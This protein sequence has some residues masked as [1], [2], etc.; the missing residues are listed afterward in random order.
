MS[1]DISFVFALIGI[2][3][4]LMASNRVRYDLVALIVV[5]ALIMGNILT[6]G[7]ALSGFG[8]SVVILVAG[9][10]V[11]GEM[12][13]RTGVARSVGDMILKH[14]GGNETQLLILLMVSAG[15]LGSVMS[16]TAVVAIFIPIVLRIAAETGLDKSR[17][18]LPMSYAALISGMLTLIATTPNLVVSDELVAQ[19][20]QALGFFSFFPIGLL[21][22]AVTIIYMLVWGRGLLGVRKAAEPAKHKRKRRAAAELWTAYQIQGEVYDFWIG[23]P[24]PLEEIRALKAKGAVIAARR[25]RA[26]N[27]ERETV[28]FRDGMELQRDDL[29][30]VRGPKDVLD[31][32][33]ARADFTRRSA[34]GARTEDWQ[35]S[36]GIADVM[37]HPEASILGQT[38]SKALTRETPELECLG[39]LRNGD[40]VPIEADTI[41][42]AG[43][44]MLV[45]G[46][47]DELDQLVEMPDDFVLLTYPKERENVV[48]MLSKFSIA[49]GILAGM[50]VLSALNIVPVTVAVLLA[51]LAAVLF[52]TM[53]ADQAYA[54]ISLPTLVL[55]AGM[56][57]LANALETTGGSALIVEHLLD[58]VGEANP[59]VMMAAL[60]LLTATL[61]LV[62]SNTASAVLVAPISITAAEAMGVSPYPMAI[63]VLIAASAAFSTPVSTP[64]VT[65][66]V[67]PGGYSF[68]D[69]LKL[70]VP[71]TLIVGLVTILV[72]PLVFPY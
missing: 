50:V 49:I 53:S 6:I 5:L 67:T 17:L 21:I 32:I 41:V 8:S 10:L 57:P 54:S 44:R 65:L 37:V 69:F 9:L 71:L 45:L 28:L 40:P 27:R 7:E 70:G 36:L 30:L 42:K 33:A 24:V 43:D 29:V 1:P 26:S 3:A 38:A 59:R 12:L 35:D 56:L 51:A 11:V 58:V 61:G 55:I 63:S 23:G 22:L 62:L 13:Q 20:Y 2:A 31:Q 19:G 34:I 25:R 72:T 48:P 52:K 66:V 15:F 14:G 18:L 4:V 39:I 60:F 47:W 68:G 64:V 46:P 16:S